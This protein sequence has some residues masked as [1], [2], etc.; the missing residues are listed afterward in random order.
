MPATTTP[1]SA[2]PSCSDLPLTLYLSSYRFG[3]QVERLRDWVTGPR[4]AVVIANAL[5]FSTD[6]PRKD[7]RIGAEIAQLQALGFAASEID[8]RLFFDNPDAL[9][10][11]LDGVGLIWTLGGNSFL[12]G[13][14]MRQS[15]LDAFLLGHRESNLVYGGYS[16][17]VV[18]ATPT[19]RGIHL[20]DPPEVVAQVYG[21]EI[22]W[23]GMALVLYC[24]AP[25]YDSPHPE[26][27]LID[28][29]IEYF[30]SHRMPF[31]TLRDGEVIITQAAP[32]S[33]ES[34]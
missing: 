10:H 1:A 30:R 22:L 24:I 9:Q 33:P 14:A 25:H 18:V 23:D 31:K 2:P 12:L 20:V 27:E 11:S 7:R 21:A 6:L 8:L 32:H 15:R 26:S 28:H 34:L 16:A 3:D 5:D 4:R 13:S 17:G 29:A 19:L